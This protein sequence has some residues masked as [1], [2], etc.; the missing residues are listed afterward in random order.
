MGKLLKATSLKEKYLVPR[1]Y[2]E[3][4]G[5]LLSVFL[6]VAC[7]TSQSTFIPTPTLTMVTSAPA[8]GIPTLTNTSVPT[9][10]SG[11]LIWTDIPAFSLKDNLLGDL[12]ENPVAIY[13][14]PSYETSDKRYPVVYFLSGFSME[15]RY[16]TDGTFQDFRL[17]ESIDQLVQDGSIK[18]MIVVIPKGQ[19]SLGGSFYANS[20][21]TGN[22]EDFIVRD[23]V[24]YV[25][26]HFRSI[27][28]ADSRGIAGHSVGGYGALNL[29]MLHPDVFSSV[30]GTSAALFDPDGLSNTMFDT[31]NIDRFLALE[32]KLAAMSREDA[33]SEFIAKRGIEDLLFTINYGIAFSPNPDR[34]A[35]YIDYPYHRT[36]GELVLDEEIWEAWERGLGGIVKEIQVY[37]DNLL[38]LDAITVDYGVSDQNEWIPRGCE[39][40]SQQ[41][42]G[43]GIAHELVS[44]SGDHG[45]LLRERIE[46]HMLPFFSDVL[47]FE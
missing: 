44:F 19:H 29:A 38:Q 10:I 41:L 16:F 4:I 27:P 1:R 30:Y 12:P 28:S 42:T 7:G 22:W 34:N 32:S 14:P 24:E 45:N 15:N 47:V 31:Q 26:T 5:V 11:Q 23:L 37:K 13:L 43:A 36:N 21:V 8:A 20:P 33:H 39:Y 46:L 35:P 40:L 3:M 9:C 2:A 6:L 18:E 17:P 25:D